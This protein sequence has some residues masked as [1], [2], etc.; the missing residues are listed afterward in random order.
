MIYHNETLIGDMR[1]ERILSGFYD[2]PELG[3][4]SVELGIERGGPKYAVGLH[5]R[6]VRHFP[7]HRLNAF[8]LLKEA[9]LQFDAAS[10]GL[11][12]L[13]EY[14]PN[15]GSHRK[16]PPRKLWRKMLGN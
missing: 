8:A 1:I 16:N 6:S 5:T 11:E 2:D 4:Y 3:D 15:G 14:E 12:G 7:R 10:F 9:L 13:P